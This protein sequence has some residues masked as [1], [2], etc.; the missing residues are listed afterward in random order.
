M[1]RSNFLD[2][3]ILL[4]LS[5]RPR[6]I[7]NGV[8]SIDES[9]K[10]SF[11]TIQSECRSFLGRLDSLPLEVLHE[12]LRYLDLRSLLR[13]S[14]VC[15]R[16]KAIVESLPAYRN[17]AKSAGY[18]FEILNRARIFDLHSVT[19]LNAALQSERCISCDAYGAFLLL[20]SAER[21]CFVCLVVNQS[22][23]MVS[24]PLAGECFVLTK[25]Q[26]KALPVMWSIPG[27]YGVPHRISRQRSIR[28]TSVK[29]VK[30]LAVQVHGSMEALTANYP[31]DPRD[32][33]SSKFDKLLWYRQA[34]LHP[35]SQDPLTI[36]DVGMRPSDDFG[37]MGAIPFPSLL[38]GSIE[39]ALWCRGCEMT[40]EEYAVEGMD[41]STLSCL[42]P[43]GCHA[44][45]FLLRMQ[46][47]AWSKA[48]FLQHAKSCHSA[49]EVIS[50]RWIGLT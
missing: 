20:L 42:V 30:E 9:T 24:L 16:G 18:I 25:Q 44:E 6:Y 15:W 2:E 45:K 5:H 36:N 19:T 14:R 7:L 31:L 27:K 35:L 1:T 32:H 47:R 21:C 26:L 49:A 4:H 10:L 17:L 38:N 23:W 37:G 29:A 48:D 3:E 41:L 39:Q 33:T 43:Q 8:I 34:P 46:Y 13:L 22:L 50:Q 28:L 11:T 40:Y 12:S